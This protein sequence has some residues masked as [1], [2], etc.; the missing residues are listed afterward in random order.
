[1]TAEM[2]TDPYKVMH[3]RILAQYLPDV[4]ADRVVPN[5]PKAANRYGLTLSSHAAAA[6]FHAAFKANPLYLL[7]QRHRGDRRIVDQL[8]H[9]PK[10]TDRA[11]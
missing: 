11:R 7:T 6:P 10:A 2:V 4:E 1:M 8:A 5:F 3:S 9:K